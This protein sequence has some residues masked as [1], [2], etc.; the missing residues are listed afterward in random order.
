MTLS[1]ASRILTRG[2]RRSN[3]A[4]GVWAADFVGTRRRAARGARGSRVPAQSG[5]AGRL[6]SESSRRIDSVMAGKC[7]VPTRSKSTVSMGPGFWRWTG[8]ITRNSG[9][10]QHPRGDQPTR[11]G[12]GPELIT[13][14][15]PPTEEHR[16][17]GGVASDAGRQA[18]G[19]TTNALIIGR[20]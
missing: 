10:N 3:R 17:E 16:D 9:R 6:E 7:Q 5:P 14:D 13:S 20:G 18:P 2:P 1:S 11:C 19:W 8:S 4:S 15:C 12:L